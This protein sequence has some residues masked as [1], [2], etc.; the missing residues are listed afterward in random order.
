MKR[1]ILI[2]IALMLVL[3][4]CQTTNPSNDVLDCNLTPLE[5]ACNDEK[6]DPSTDNFV[7][8]LLASLTIEEKVGQMIQAERAYISPDQVR[9]YNIGSVLSGG[10]SFPS[11]YNDDLD[12]WYDMVKAYQDAALV[13]SSGIP[14]LYGI[15]AVHGNNNVYGSTIFPHNINLGMANNPDLMFDIGEATAKEMKAVGIHWNFSPA[16]S[17]VE[18]IQWGRTYEGF[19]E[20]DVI[21]NNLVQSYIAGLQSEDVVATVK[22][23][24]GDG[25][26]TEGI[27]QG[28]T[29]ESE[30]YIR[31]HYLKPYELAI[32]AG[33]DSVMISFSSLNG[34]KMTGNSY[35]IN[36]VLKDELGFEGI[37]LSDWNAVHQLEGDFYTQLVTSINAGI[38]MVMEPTEWEQAYQNI[39]LAVEN[40][41]ISIS[42]IDDAVKRI[43][44]VKHNNNI[45]D[46]P[47]S[48]LDSSVVYSDAHKQLAKQ[49]A[50]ESFVLLE[51]NNAL[52]LTGN[53]SIYL[54]GPAHDHVGYLSGGWTTYW[55]GNTNPDIGVGSSIEDAIDIALTNRTGQ[56]VNTV[57][58]ADTVIVVFAEIPYTEGV[59]DTFTPTLFDGLSHPDN[60]TAYQE[61]L[62]AKQQGK[63]VIGILASGRPLVIGNDIETFDAFF[64]IF[65]PGSEG[66]PAVSD[67]LF[68][69]ADFSGKLS[70]TWPF[71]LSDIGQIHTQDNYTT[72]SKA[73]PFGYGLTYNEEE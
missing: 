58:A 59:G 65:L 13:S 69:S 14:I 53:E 54:T 38:D 4:G 41:D 61:A 19:G 36:E 31:E 20:D 56:L 5:D 51:N 29:Q 30:A 64:A 62:L 40:D 72:L 52:P 42:R 34:E 60:D 22:H 50:I 37:V 12:T 39:L 66:G 16:V 45:F 24:I 44:T 46:E 25:G 43:L 9:L 27:D 23:Y 10:G 71:T 33:V 11:Q 70:Y 49:A 48:R 68:G 21:H 7:M 17:V 6:I 47:I 8:T 32:E 26:T 28:N 55:Q 63:T 57:D 1:L 18:N 35:W 67:L 73:Y 15:D 2:L 3:V